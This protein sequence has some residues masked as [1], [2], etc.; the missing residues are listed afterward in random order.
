MGGYDSEYLDTRLM[1]IAAPVGVLSSAFAS[2]R[3]MAKWF[4]RRI[5]ATAGGGFGY[6]RF[7]KW[8]VPPRPRLA[9]TTTLCQSRQGILLDTPIP[10]Q[11]SGWRKNRAP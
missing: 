5:S 4:F 10:T 1:V 9:S 8:V 2:P 6:V 11:P 7:E 3:S